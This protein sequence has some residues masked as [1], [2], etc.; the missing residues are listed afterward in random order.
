MTHAGMSSTAD[1]VLDSG[2]PSPRMTGP[3]ASRGLG[4]GRVYSVI[5]ALNKATAYP[6]AAQFHVGQY[7]MIWLP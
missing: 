4:P 1:N 3:P 5:S 2:R 6:A 7:C